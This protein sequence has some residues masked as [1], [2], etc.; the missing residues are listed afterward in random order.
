MVYTLLKMV[1]LEWFTIALP[2]LYI[3]T[4]GYGYEYITTAGQHPQLL[5]VLPIHA[6][7]E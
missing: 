2:T 1:N 3:Y 7:Q 6:S 5:V 4:I